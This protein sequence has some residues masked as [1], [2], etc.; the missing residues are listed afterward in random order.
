VLTLL[1]VGLPLIILLLLGKR[2]QELLPKVRDWM[3]TNSWVV[4]EAVIVFFLALT[5]SSLG[6]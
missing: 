5:V 1:L 3:S 6:S 2:A 4:N